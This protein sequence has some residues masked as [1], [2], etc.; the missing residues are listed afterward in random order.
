MFLNLLGR[1]LTRVAAICFVVWVASDEVIQI[2]EIIK[3]LTVGEFLALM[4]I[5][6]IC[7]YATDQLDLWFTELRIWLVDR[8]LDKR[9]NNDE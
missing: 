8:K 1:S 4:M 7:T 3:S 6:M 5:M 2:I 9:S